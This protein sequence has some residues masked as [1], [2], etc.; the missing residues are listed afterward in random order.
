MDAGNS[1]TNV[2]HALAWSV[3]ELQR[4]IESGRKSN[5]DIQVLREFF[6]DDVDS[7][8]VNIPRQ[9][10]A[11]L[12][13]IVKGVYHYRRTVASHVL[14]IMISTESRNRK[15]YALPVQC[16]PYSS[17]KDS[18][19]RVVLNSVIREMISLGM[20]VAGLLHIHIHTVY[21]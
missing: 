10:S 16:I 1:T 6:Q 11:I 4:L 18:K 2:L 12:V 13:E 20:K 15:P 17:F 14:V 8:G 21:Y 19:I 5:V 7:V 3:D 9:V